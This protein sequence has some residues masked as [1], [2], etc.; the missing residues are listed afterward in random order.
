MKTKAFL[1]LIVIAALVLAVFVGCGSMGGAKSL[2]NVSG[3]A[4]GSAQG[5]GG[6][7]EVTVTIKD[8]FI[9]DVSINAASETMAIAGAVLRRAPDM[10][11]EYNSSD[12][13]NVSGATKTSLAI[14]QAAQEAIDKIVKG[15]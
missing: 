12:I 7:V 14:K 9:T 3:T 1:P 11:K 2:G 8:G 13:D 6:P 15:N 10:I 4:T 5:Y